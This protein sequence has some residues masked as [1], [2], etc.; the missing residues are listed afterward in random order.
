MSDLNNEGSGDSLLTEGTKDVDPGATTG[1]T[2][3][4]DQGGGDGGQPNAPAWL[5]QVSDDLKADPDLTK[6]ATISD[7]ARNYK[8]LLGKV[9]TPPETAGAYELE[10]PEILKGAY[11]NDDA[12]E[13]FKKAAFDMGLSQLQAKT[14][15][16]QFMAA[17]QKQMQASIDARNNSRKEA[18]DN[19]QKEWGVDYQANMELTKRAIKTFGTTDFSNLLDATQLGN[20][21]IVAKTFLAI[22]K[23]MSEDTLVGGAT[24]VTKADDIQSQLNRTYPTMVKKKT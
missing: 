20:D 11:V 13:T 16:A 9:N 4:D 15:F 24:T 7:M 6:H 1:T 8:D 2:N 3:T 21:P 18:M 17:N 23:A 12:L 19:L 14:V 10:V 5:S 22:G